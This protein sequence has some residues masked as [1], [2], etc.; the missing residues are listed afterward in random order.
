[1]QSFFTLH[2]TNSIKPIQNTIKPIQ[3]IKDLN[4]MSL[5]IIAQLLN[6]ENTLYRIFKLRFD[7]KKRIAT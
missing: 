1:M 6:F 5:Q 3:N 7:Y 2:F 4:K